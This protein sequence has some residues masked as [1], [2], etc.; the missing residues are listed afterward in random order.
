[1]LSS[2]GDFIFSAINTSNCFDKNL[3]IK[4]ND[5]LEIHIVHDDARYLYYYKFLEDRWTK[6]ENFNAF[7]IR[8]DYRTV[9]KGITKPEIST[10]LTN[11]LK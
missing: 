1:M 7:D 5:V 6:A 9:S 11:V 2:I 4:N 10:V 8:N 3:A